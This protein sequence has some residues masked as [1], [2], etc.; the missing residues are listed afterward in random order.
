M[1]TGE[2]PLNTRVL[3]DDDVV[4]VVEVDVTALV[5]VVALTAKV[6][7]EITKSDNTNRIPKWIESFISSLSRTRRQS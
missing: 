2:C 1:S 7:P 5:V 3:R 4:V 6:N